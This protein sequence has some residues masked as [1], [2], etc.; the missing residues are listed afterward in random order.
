MKRAV[1]EGCGGGVGVWRGREGESEGRVRG[2]VPGTSN[3]LHPIALSPSVRPTLLSSS[4]KPPSGFPALLA[5]LPPPVR[6]TLS[7]A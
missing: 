4:T 6:A 5:P 2:G 7:E 1:R 3:T